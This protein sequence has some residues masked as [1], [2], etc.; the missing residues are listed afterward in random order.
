VAPDRDQGRYAPAGYGFSLPAFLDAS[1]DALTIIGLD[2]TIQQCNL[3]T[4]R[5]LGYESPEELIGR[6]VME[7]LVPRDRQRAAEGIAEV[8]RTGGSRDR[9]YTLVRRDGTEYPV[10]LST[11]VIRGADQ[12]PLG[13]VSST[14][15]VS[16]RRQ[17]EAALR[18]SEQR[19]RLLFSQASEG[20]FI[21]STASTTS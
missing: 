5:L 1:P 12:Q 2:G 20:I 4:A 17:A 6:P 21:M 14:R 10:E 15:D 13:L 18:S 8:L 16:R 11:G 9:E 19:Y 3:A 7:L